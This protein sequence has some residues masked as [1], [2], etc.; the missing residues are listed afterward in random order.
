MIQAAAAATS[1]THSHQPHYYVRSKEN[2]KHR[3]QIDQ[4]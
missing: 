2:D 3:T 4:Q 1:L